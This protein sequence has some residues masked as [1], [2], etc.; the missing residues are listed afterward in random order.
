MQ[1]EAFASATRQRSESLALTAELQLGRI[2][3]GE[4]LLA[5]RNALV[6]LTLVGLKDAI[7]GH[8]RIGQKS[9]TA[10]QLRIVLDAFG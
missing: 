4:R 10:F 7:G 6:G 8:P 9:V 2:V 3:H 5:L 1:K